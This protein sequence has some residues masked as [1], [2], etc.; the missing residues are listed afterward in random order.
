VV[1]K[2]E[3]SEIASGCFQGGCKS[4]VKYCWLARGL[5]AFDQ[6]PDPFDCLTSGIMGPFKYSG[7]AGTEPQG[8]CA[9]VAPSV[10][11]EFTFLCKL[12]SQLYWA[13]V[14][15]TIWVGGK[16]LMRVP[17]IIV[18]KADNRLATATREI[19]VNGANLALV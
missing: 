16:W 7:H 2:V 5:K 17:V 6:D 9:R 12:D 10:A 4:H 3:N 8:L 1:Q 19:P 11:R 14:R 18:R 15:S 13:A